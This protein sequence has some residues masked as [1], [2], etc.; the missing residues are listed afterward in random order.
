M[1]QHFFSVYFTGLQNTVWLGSGVLKVASAP[2]YARQQ[3]YRVAVGSATRPPRNPTVPRENRLNDFAGSI[4]TI[5]FVNQL[6]S[7]VKML[8][9]LGR[10]LCIVGRRA[11]VFAEMRLGQLPLAPNNNNLRRLAYAA[12]LSSIYI[13]F[14][15]LFLCGVGGGLST[16][17]FRDFPGMAIAVLV[18]VWHSL[19]HLVN[20]HLFISC[21]CE[22]RTYWQ[23]CKC[24]HWSLTHGAIS[25]PQEGHP[26]ANVE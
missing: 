7:C 9:E 15:A 1:Q 16:C 18:A 20:I 14:L 5:T 21:P 22:R 10:Y 23:K 13:Y 3:H 12:R 11:R 17:C 26:L 6:Q 2:G 4:P 25:L 24:K 8:K 19:R